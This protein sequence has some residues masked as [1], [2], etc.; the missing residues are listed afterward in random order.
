MTTELKDLTKEI[1]N[2]ARQQKWFDFHVLNYSGSK[3]TIA[4][5]TDL[6]YYH[7]LEVI[8]EDVFFA[9]V[10][11]NGWRSN[12]NSTVFTFPDNEIELNRQYEIEQG[13]QLFVFKTEE[14]R[15]NV[16]IAAKKLSF[17]TDTVFYHDKQDLKEKERIAD[18]VKKQRL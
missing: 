7:T 1:D 11:F 2:I 6:T 3:L 18:F 9:L 10:F 15:N 12:T 8:F 13:Y 17:N 14:Y 16:V 4:G 5:G